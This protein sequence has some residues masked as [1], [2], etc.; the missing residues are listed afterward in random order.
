MNRTIE[1]SILNFK[2]TF[3]MLKKIFTQ[4]S[5]LYKLGMVMLF[6]FLLLLCYFPFN[7]VTVLGINSVVKPMKFALSIWIYSWTMALILHYVKDIRKVKIYSWVAVVCMSFE[8][9]AITL[10]ALRGTVSHF[11]RE[12]TFGMIL[13]S[14]MGVFILTITLWTAYITYIFIKQKTY[15]LHP[16][17]VLS[18][19]ISLTYFVVFSLF[20]GYISGLPGHTVGSADGGKGLLFLNWSMLFGDLRVAHFFGI[21]SLQFVPLFAI[22]ATKYLDDKNSIIAIK[23]FSFVYLCF[24]LFVLVQALLGIPFVK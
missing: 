9:A 21:H 18:I 17:I 11:N 12:N 20:G 16:A 13:F 10:Q 6:I 15:D 4:N 19:K 14:L 3:T 23:V 24:I 8:Q 1:I 7:N 22:V 2:L 5:I